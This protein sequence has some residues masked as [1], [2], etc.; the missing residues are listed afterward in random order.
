MAKTDTFHCSVI[1]PERSVLECD[2]VFAAIPAHD[3]EIGI[4]RNRG[5]LV[6]KLGIGVL[7]VQSPSG[8]QSV[9]VDGGFAQ[10]IE[11]RV[12]VLTQQAQLAS[13]IDPA[14]AE[15]ALAAARD[16]TAHDEAG[17]D[18]RRRALRRARVRLALARARR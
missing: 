8:D 14:A 18:A 9:F 6:C 3:G 11:N 17:V 7:R 16:M 2:A 10:V 4:L 15:K 12:S 1:T 5:P 13:E